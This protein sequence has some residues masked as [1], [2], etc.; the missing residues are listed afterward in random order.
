MLK[1]KRYPKKQGTQPLTLKNNN[2]CIE[3]IQHLDVCVLLRVGNWKCVLIVNVTLVLSHYIFHDRLKNFSENFRP[4][5]KSLPTPLSH[6]QN[7]H[8]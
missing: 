1:K 6:L 4:L 3:F 2:D 7:R 5:K 8:G